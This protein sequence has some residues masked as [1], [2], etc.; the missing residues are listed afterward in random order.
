MLGWLDVKD[1][2]RPEAK[3]VINYLHAKN[4][5]TILLTGDRYARTKQ[6]GDQLGLLEIIAE[7]TPEQKLDHIAKLNTAIP[8]A[9][10]GDGITM[11]SSCQA[12]VG[13][14]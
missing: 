6:L 11:P 7:Q 8:T 1:E 4:I 9:M 3:E 12:T 5:K 10:I 14:L 13:I 2:V